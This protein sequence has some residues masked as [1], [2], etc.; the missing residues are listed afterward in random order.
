MARH[1]WENNPAYLD[2][3]DPAATPNVDLWHEPSV[4][5]VDDLTTL[6]TE[7]QPGMPSLC[8]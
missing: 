1:P 6:E 8:T 4:G 5:T 7:Y 2:A 3:W